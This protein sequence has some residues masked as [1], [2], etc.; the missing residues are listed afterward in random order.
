MNNSQTNV[1]IDAFYKSVID[2][3]KG[4]KSISRVDIEMDDGTGP[5]KLSYETIDDR[6]KTPE[7]LG[8]IALNG[9]PLNKGEKQ[10][11]D[12]LMGWVERAF[13]TNSYVFGASAELSNGQKYQIKFTSEKGFQTDQ[14][15]R[16][17]TL[18]TDLPE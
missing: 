13:M 1:G 6:T 9:R 12:S 15:Q 8:P 7:V 16:K 4:D 14:T 11:F 18:E 2:T 5:M 10:K 3:Y 17:G